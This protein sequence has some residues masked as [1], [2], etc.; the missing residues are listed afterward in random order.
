MIFPILSNRTFTHKAKKGKI[1]CLTCRLK[2]CV[3][4]CRFEV[5]DCPRPPRAA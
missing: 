4:K 5:V 1:T 2:G 3:G